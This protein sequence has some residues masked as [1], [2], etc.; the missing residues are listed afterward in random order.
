[1]CAKA[2]YREGFKALAAELR[3]LVRVAAVRW[4][5]AQRAAAQ[6]PVVPK[7]SPVHHF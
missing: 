4:R 6:Q 2:D 7:K 1:M 5:H 3:R